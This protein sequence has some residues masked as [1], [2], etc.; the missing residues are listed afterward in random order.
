LGVKGPNDDTEGYSDAAYDKAIIAVTGFLT[1]TLIAKKP[2]RSFT[3]LQIKQ[4]REW[5]ETNAP[6]FLEFPEGAL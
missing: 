5:L 6:D 3:S 2:Y 4:I 1:D